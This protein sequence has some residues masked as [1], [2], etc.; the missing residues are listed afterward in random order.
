MIPSSL[1]FIDRVN[2]KFDLHPKTVLE[3]GSMDRNLKIGARKQF[4]GCDYLGADIEYGPNVDTIAD[5]YHL[6]EYF[7]KGSF[8][9]VLGLHLFEHTSKPWLIL[10]QIKYILSTGGLM[11]V[12]IP[13][14]GYPVHNYPGD[15]WR[16]TE[17]A[18]KEVIF[19]G[20]DVLAVEPAKSKYH[21]HPFINRVGRKQ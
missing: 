21:K 8:D 7:D 12:S 14:I 10:E 5:A 11:Y 3:I 17:M 20:Y 6:D 4:P 2:L 1:E 19:E 9:A 16:V 15:Y 18:V 13:T